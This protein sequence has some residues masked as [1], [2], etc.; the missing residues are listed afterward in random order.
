MLVQSFDVDKVAV[1]GREG[2][3]V[4][5]HV[6]RHADEITMS[7]VMPTGLLEYTNYTP[8]RLHNGNVLISFTTAVNNPYIDSLFFSA[9]LI[10]FLK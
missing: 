8:Y 5:Q 3:Y 1:P 4:L 9:T 6:G 7:T 2:Y 10:R